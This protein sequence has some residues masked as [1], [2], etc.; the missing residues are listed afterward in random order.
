MKLSKNSYIRYCDVNRSRVTGVDGWTV[1][2]SVVAYT[3]SPVTYITAS[4]AFGT[5]TTV[6]HFSDT[7]YRTFFVTN[8]T[9][10]SATIVTD[11]YSEPFADYYVSTD[12]WTHRPHYTVSTSFHRSFFT[13]AIP[14]S[15]A[16]D[17]ISS[18][19]RREGWAAEDISHLSYNWGTDYANGTDCWV[20]D[21]TLGNDAPL[22]YV[23]YTLHGG[24]NTQQAIGAWNNVGPVNLRRPAPRFA[25]SC[26]RPARLPYDSYGAQFL[27]RLPADKYTV[28]NVTYTVVSHITAKEQPGG[29]AGL[30]ATD[31]YYGKYTL[32]NNN[33][34]TTV[35]ISMYSDRHS[36]TDSFVIYPQRLPA[37]FTFISSGTVV[38]GLQHIPRGFYWVTSGGASFP[39]DAHAS[40][41]YP[42]V[43]LYELVSGSVYLVMVRIAPGWTCSEYVD[44]GIYTVKGSSLV[45]APDVT[46]NVAD[47]VM[48][49][50]PPVLR[51]KGDASGIVLADDATIALSDNL[52]VR[53]VNGTE[54]A[55]FHDNHINSQRM[56]INITAGNSTCSRYMASIYTANKV[57]VIASPLISQ[58]NQEPSKITCRSQYNV[59]SNYSYF[60]SG[61][62]SGINGGDT[63]Y[64]GNHVRSSYCCSSAALSQIIELV[65][66]FGGSTNMSVLQN[67]DYL[68]EFIT[69]T[70]IY[71][72]GDTH[73]TGSYYTSIYDV[74]SPMEAITYYSDS[75][76]PLTP[77][78]YLSLGAKLNAARVPIRYSVNPA[79][80][81]VGS[82]A[83]ASMSGFGSA[84]YSMRG[85][86][87][88]DHGYMHTYVTAKPD[89][90]PVSN[91]YPT[92]YGYNINVTYSHWPAPQNLLNCVLPLANSVYTVVS[93]KLRISPVHAFSCDKEASGSYFKYSQ[94]SNGYL[95]SELVP[96]GNR[97]YVDVS[98]GHTTATAE[99]RYVSYSGSVSVAHVTEL[100][101]RIDSHE[102]SEVVPYT[103]VLTYTEYTGASTDADFD[104]S[105]GTSTLSV[106]RGFTAPTIDAWVSEFKES[107]DRFTPL[108]LPETPHTGSA[109]RSSASYGYD[110]YE[111]SHGYAYICHLSESRIPAT[112][113]T[114]TWLVTMV[115]S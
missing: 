109:S 2:S 114:Y 94:N 103:A 40:A 104:P 25:L 68:D 21:V 75:L 82:D 62:S 55:R 18:D 45:T 36:T 96:F 41:H 72:E 9:I 76:R 110:E 22:H 51:Q 49:Y 57:M 97:I 13:T 39:V 99:K 80:M 67:T 65:P 92:T 58:T 46:V 113:D 48:V 90:A 4:D 105:T 74:G 81:W 14:S 35:S 73:R 83:A 66:S 50:E 98:C 27:F 16:L 7:A 20:V 101:L 56:L 42:S 91:E 31:S 78:I 19:L 23:S 111:Y 69:Y 63:R 32:L 29:T 61:N 3:G 30:Y 108:T 43:G 79:S 59:T 60:H 88:L 84:G 47:F 24:A 85:S 28:G 107:A 33:D 15:V 17:W 112:W 87:E 54:D 8:S 38:P 100:Y 37:E 95:A 44:S 6:T 64:Y 5:R 115:V 106:F 102:D 86:C 77:Y 70:S 89:S 93:S 11:T 12:L 53:V 34:P 26:V 10:S 52:Q 1:H 71:N